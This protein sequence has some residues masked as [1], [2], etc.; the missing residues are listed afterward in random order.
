MEKVIMSLCEIRRKTAYNSGFARMRIYFKSSYIS[1]V[2]NFILMENIASRTSQPRKAA[3]RFAALT[4][5]AKPT[6]QEKF[7]QLK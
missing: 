4:T 1:F 5:P 2:I 3:K 6:H 7:A